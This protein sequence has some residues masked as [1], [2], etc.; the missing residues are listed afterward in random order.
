M[1]IVLGHEFTG[2]VVEVGAIPASMGLFKPGDRVVVNPVQH[3]NACYNCA[4]G[5]TNL[6][7]NL[8]VPGVNADG[9]FAEYVVSRYTGLFKLADNVSYAAGALIE[10]LACAVYAM[11]KLEIV[12][13]QFGRHLR[14]WSDRNHDDPDRQGAPARARSSWSA[15]ATTASK[16]PRSG[17][18]TISSTRRTPHPPTTPRT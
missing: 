1:P 6:C 11:N 17:A 12:P 9:A 18:R 5:N 2:E 7:S 3:C 4:S 8:Y 15:P 10:P 16:R 13:G 14:P